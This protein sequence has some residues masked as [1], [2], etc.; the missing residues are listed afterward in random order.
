MRKREGK[1]ENRILITRPK[2]G[3]RDCD[4]DFYY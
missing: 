1:R 3:G 2:I 4:Y